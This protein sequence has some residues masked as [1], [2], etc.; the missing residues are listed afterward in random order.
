M[1]PSDIE[2]IAALESDYKHMISDVQE[3]KSDLKALPEKMS[4]AVKEGV[5]ECREIQD[6]RSSKKDKEDREEREEREN[7]LPVVKASAAGKVGWVVAICQGL[8]IF[9]KSMG[10]F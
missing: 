6:L 7:R 10:W 1:A 2:R 8:W 3:I 9:A 5:A 4:Q